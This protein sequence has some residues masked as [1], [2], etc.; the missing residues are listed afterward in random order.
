M[1]EKKQDPK[2]QKKQKQE[3]GN[4]RDEKPMP[5][6]D[7]SGSN[8][9]AMVE[10]IMSPRSSPDKPKLNLDNPGY[11]RRMVQRFSKGSA[12]TRTIPSVSPPTEGFKSPKGSSQLSQGPFQ[13]F[14]PQGGVPKSKNQSPNCHRTIPSG[15]P[16]GGFK[17]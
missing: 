4:E 2:D 12:V 15:S 3:H 13:W 8:V 5:G 7:E 17:S 1:V 6:Q 10:R 9:K 16:H 14:S 11:V